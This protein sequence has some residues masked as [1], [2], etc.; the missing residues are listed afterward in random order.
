MR[1]N[2]VKRATERIPEVAAL[3]E[4][5]SAGHGH[6]A[7]RVEAMVERHGAAVLRVANQ[8]SL[9][10]DDALDAYQRAFEIYLRKLDTV[11]P[12][13]E[14][15]WLR[16]VVK[17]EAMAI[18]RGRLDSVDRDD[19]DLDSS[20]HSGLREV[21]DEVAGG[22]RIDRSVEALR[23]LKPDEARAL[24]LKAEGLSYQEIGKHFGWTYTKVNRSI[25]EG[26][27]RFLKVFTRLEEGEE[28]EAHQPALTALA[29][30]TATSAEVVSIRPHLRHCA[31]CR[32]TVREMRFSRTRRLALLLPLGWLTRL[33]SRSDVALYTAANGGGRFGPAAAVLGIC[34]SGV[35]AGAACVMSGALPAPPLIAHLQSKPEAKAPVAK[36]VVVKRKPHAP[37]RIAQATP[38]PRVYAPPTATATP[39]RVKTKTARERT[40]VTRKKTPVAKSPSTTEFTF[41]GS[42]G[43]AGS[44]S[45]GGS[46]P[47]ASAASTGGGG[48]G[49]GSGG[50]TASAPKSSAGGEFGFEGG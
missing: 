23:A 24:L 32:A 2:G 46:G 5:E 39:Q 47:V 27:A 1:L 26:R 35:G 10:H 6:G 13:T 34:L 48:S 9:C 18:R 19:V 40:K 41:E 16:V 28:C 49:S 42:G 20:V 21:D 33:V 43:S 7:R 36:K 12:A 8:F 11:D 44:S 45:S 25:T 4:R 14:G 29:A 30:G 15:A 3:G 37:A 22:E 31:T 50:K 17:H 38:T